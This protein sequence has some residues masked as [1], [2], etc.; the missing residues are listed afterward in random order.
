M[1]VSGRAQL[2]TRTI[3]DSLAP[4]R[5]AGRG[6]G[7]G[8]FE[9]KTSS[10][11][12]SPPASL[13]GEGVLSRFECSKVQPVVWCGCQVAPCLEGRS[14]SRSL[15]NYTGPG[16]FR[17]SAV[18]SGNASRADAGSFADSGKVGLSPPN[19][20]SLCKRTRQIVGTMFR[21]RYG[22]KSQG[23]ISRRHESVFCRR[24]ATR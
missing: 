2:D 17:H 18:C 13:G 10:P 5:S 7:R 6:L 12:P 4:Q 11:R 8:D 23:C 19:S 16:F 21:S 14:R 24:F 15:S 3:F 22:F 9:L 1:S 20:R